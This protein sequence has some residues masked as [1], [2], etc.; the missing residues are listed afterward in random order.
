MEFK[1]K[2][3]GAYDSIERQ[4]L[5]ETKDPHVLIRMLFEKSCLLLRRS[6]DSLT[7]NNE[8]SFRKSSL[9]ALQIVLSLRFVL[10][11]DEGDELSKSLFDTYTSIAASLFRAREQEDPESLKKIYDALDELRQ[12][13]V[14]LSED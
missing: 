6:I 7:G 5:S 10:K 13:W 1:A 4:K 2:G 11:T 3:I 12:A 8:E 14:V 9:H